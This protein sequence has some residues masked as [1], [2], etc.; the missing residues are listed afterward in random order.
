MSKAQLYNDLHP[1]KSLK[2]TGFKD[3]MTAIRT[4]NLISKRSLRYQYDVINTMYYRAKYHPHITDD[5]KKAM[6]IFKKWLKNYTKLKTLEDKKYP[7]LSL[8]TIAKYEKIAL[9]NQ[10]QLTFPFQPNSLFLQE[11][12]ADWQF[13]LGYL[14][15]TAIFRAIESKYPNCQFKHAFK[16]ML[17]NLPPR[18][19]DYTIF[20]EVSIQQMD[21][22]V[23][24][25]DQLVFCGTFHYTT[26]Q[27][28]LFYL[29]KICQEYSFEIAEVQLQLSGLV[30]HS[31]K[32]YA[33][34]SSY[35]LN[36]IF[37]R[38]SIDWS[39]TSFPSHYFT[40]LTNNLPCVS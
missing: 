36:V 33:E 12:Y 19:L 11:S 6:V 1:D 5:M 26:E 3:S 15:P 8:K 24:R 2:N 30:D 18:D 16:P 21:L 39:S 22:L 17:S 28:A 32:L 27:D 25:A 13:Y 10:L 29:L 38:N 7:W 34:L 14:M 23:F 37:R 20:I 31:S 40:L 4:I 9:Q 35:F